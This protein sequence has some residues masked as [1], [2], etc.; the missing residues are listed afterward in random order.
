MM[1]GGVFTLTGYA[2]SHTGPSLPLA[3]FLVAVLAAL[4]T[5]LVYAELGSARP[6]AGG[7]YLWIREGLGPVQGHF[8]G[9]FSWCGHSVACAVY[10]ISF[11][12][13]A[14]HLLNTLVLPYFDLTLPGPDRVWRVL[15]ALLTIAFLSLVNFRGVKH[16]EL[17]GR[18]VVPVSVGVLLVFVTLGFLSIFTTPPATT[19]EFMPFGI[20]GLLGGMGLMFLAFQGFEVVA[21]S[22]EEM[23]APQKNIPRALFA[24]FLII[25]V[26]YLL[27]TTVAVFGV[28]AAV[29]GWVVLSDAGE[30]AMAAA[31][32]Y[33]P[34][35]NLLVPL[36][37]LGGATVAMAALSATIF[38]ASHIFYAMARHGRSLPVEFE[39]IHPKYGTPFVGV[40]ASALLMIVL[41]AAMP[42]KDIAAIADLFFFFLFAQV[43]LAFIQFRRKFPDLP[44]PFRAPLY[45]WLSIL[46]LFMFVLLTIQVVQIS[47]WSLSFFLGWLV[48]GM[49]IH[50]GYV[51]RHESGEFVNGK[52]VEFGERAQEESH[53]FLLVPVIAQTSWWREILPFSIALAKHHHGE[54]FVL[55][56]VEQPS[57]GEKQWTP[58]LKKEVLDLHQELVRD[59][60]GLGITYTVRAQFT[61]DIVDTILL[62][63]QKLDADLLVIPHEYLPKS[64]RRR[65]GLERRIAGRDFRRVLRESRCD[66]VIVRPTP[67]WGLKQVLVPVTRSSHNRL[68]GQVALSLASELHG[69]VTLLHV[70]LDES[71]SEKEWEHLLA[72]LGLHQDGLNL[73]KRWI[74]G[75]DTVERII[76]ASSEYDLVLMGA[77][78]ASTFEAAVLGPTAREIL[79]RSAKPVLVCYDHL[80]LP[81]FLPARR[82]AEELMKR[83][84]RVQETPVD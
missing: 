64:Q 59:L 66:L 43:H 72:E 4:P 78:E 1:G 80:E 27:V 76:E 68:L 29:P 23:K 19:G 81:V 53:H 15:L 70:S 65:F 25:L 44:R 16:T 45:P 12:F 61:S 67:H 62:A 14:T 26:L 57:E 32:S 11:G 3:I 34:L 73:R 36:V 47:P 50:R 48:L 17:F 75:G 40:L 2:A 38:S 58:E 55:V 49:L 71:E 83:I 77:K 69:E 74:A 7:G 31:A 33:M 54:L 8:S 21:Q 37:S 28:K 84:R 51:E 46:A 42:I 30:G 9:W 79:E 39:A 5:V 13:Y 56:L 24:S 82:V 6:E 52:I 63:V 20:G 22:S 10:A 41:V 60:S 35:P 18:A